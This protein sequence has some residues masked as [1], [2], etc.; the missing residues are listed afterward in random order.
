MVCLVG[1]LRNCVARA[2]RFDRY[3]TVGRSVISRRHKALIAILISV[4]LVSACG[5][6]NDGAGETTG[7][8]APTTSSS[9]STDTTVEESAG[10]D[11]E[12]TECVDSAQS[13]T[14][15]HQSGSVRVI[16]PGGEVEVI[17]LGSQQTVEITPV[18]IVAVDS[19]G[20]AHARFVDA[21]TCQ[22]GPDSHNGTRILTRF[23]VQQRD[24][25]YQF[26]GRSWCTI[27]GVSG[28]VVLSGETVLMLN[29]EEHSFRVD[30]DP[31]VDTLVVNG[32][33]DGIDVQLA[34]QDEPRTVLP[35]EFAQVLYDNGDPFA[36]EIEEFA[37]EDPP[38]LFAL[39]V[40]D[41]EVFSD[42]ENG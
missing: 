29:G 40:T 25:L 39:E 13:D 27:S 12:R 32:G 3:P 2:A 23:P 21:G 34:S 7:T 4:A 20:Y 42:L 38:A 8:S 26:W 22:L 37:R 10:G 14:V 9:T 31:G 19:T 15:C 5:N 30:H 6:S 36:I 18:T 24:L 17:E 16:G 41:E 35:G 1:D 33:P 11:N 28:R